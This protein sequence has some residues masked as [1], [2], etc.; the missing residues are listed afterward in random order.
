MN[1]INILK[2]EKPIESKEIL[3]T[4]D[5]IEEKIFMG[6]RMNEGI[7]FDDFKKEFNIEF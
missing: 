6:L 2:N 3:N 7:S 1:I 4:E 5:K